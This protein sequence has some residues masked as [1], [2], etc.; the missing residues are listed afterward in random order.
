M[1][2]ELCIEICLED[3]LIISKTIKDLDIMFEHD[4]GKIVVGKHNVV[5][6]VDGDNVARN[7]KYDPYC[8]FYPDCSSLSKVDGKSRV[9]RV[10]LKRPVYTNHNDR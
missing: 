8:K 3:E 6:A 1:E 4:T 7:E 9:Y 10:Y 2:Y 5:F